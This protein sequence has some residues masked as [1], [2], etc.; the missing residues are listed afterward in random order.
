MSKIQFEPV[1][2]QRQSELVARQIKSRVMATD[3]S[4]GDR[5]PS[6]QTLTRDLNVSRPVVREAMRILETNG[7]VDIK[8]GRGGG[9]FV[10]HNFHKPLRDTMI[11]LVDSGR[12]DIDQVNS[13]RLLLEPYSAIQ[14]CQNATDDELR[15]LKVLLEDSRKNWGNA[16]LLKKNN[17]KFHVRMAEISGNPILAILV[18]SI[19][20]LL[21]ELVFKRLDLNLEHRFV[22]IHEGIYDA[23]QSRNRKLV[24]YLVKED[25]I[26]INKELAR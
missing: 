13:I 16:S 5:L 2:T 12:V 26:E 6:E 11:S 15:S 17:L 21:A 9:I 14:A 20:E 1:D 7:L 25:L 10:S 24:E 23:L 22:D 4:A 18:R 19:I 3:I 8:K